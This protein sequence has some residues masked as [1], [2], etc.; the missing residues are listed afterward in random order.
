MKRELCATFPIAPRASEVFSRRCIFGFG[1][2]SLFPACVEQNELHAR[3]FTASDATTNLRSLQSRRFDTS[4]ETQ[5]LQA[6]AGVLQDLGFQIDESRPSVGLVAGSKDRSAVEAGQ[7]AAQMLLVL[8][9]AAARSQHR[10]VLDRDQRIRIAVV[11][12]PARE[13]NALSARATMQRVVTNTDNR[14]SRIETLD[15]PALYQEFFNL[16]SQSLFLTAHEI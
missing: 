6:V 11:V 12:R 3:H 15:D 8:L 9:A 14:L 13:P 7:V 2:I 4:D 16:L 1:V 10:A 5:M